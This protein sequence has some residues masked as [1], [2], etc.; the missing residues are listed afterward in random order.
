MTAD[1]LA[2]GARHDPPRGSRGERR[3]ALV[4]NAKR[5]TEASRQFSVGSGATPDRSDGQN[6]VFNRL[7]AEGVI[8]LGGRK[9]ATSLTEEVAMTE[10]S[11]VVGIVPKRAKGRH[12]PETRRLQQRDPIGPEAP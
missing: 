6:Y 11:S 9:W 8:S 2:F 10:V 3:A 12:G 4:L 1:R 7:K 5:G